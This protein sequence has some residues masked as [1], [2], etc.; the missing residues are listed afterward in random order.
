[1]KTLN[2]L[3]LAITTGIVCSSIITSLG[4]NGIPAV[5]SSCS[6][7]AVIVLAAT[8]TATRINGMED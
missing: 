6:L 1:M 3:L 7:E 5:I 4:I 8:L 2:S